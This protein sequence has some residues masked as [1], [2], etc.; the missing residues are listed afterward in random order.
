LL[1][2]MHAVS[3]LFFLHGGEC[4]GDLSAGSCTSR[5]DEGE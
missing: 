2:G 5:R 1:P 4:G 3:A